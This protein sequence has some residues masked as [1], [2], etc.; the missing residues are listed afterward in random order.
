[1]RVLMI[2]GTAAHP[3]GVEAFCAR[4]AEAFGDDGDIRLDF[5]PAD[6]AFLPPRLWPSL[7]LRAWRTVRQHRGRIGGIWLHYVNL[8]DLAYLAMARLMGVP[9][10]VTPHLGTNWRSQSNPL[11]RNISRFLL[12]R[13]KG[14]ALLSPTQEREIA[15]PAHVRRWQVRTF[16]PRHLWAQPVPERDASRPLRLIHSARLSEGKGSFLFVDLCAI[17]RDRGVPFS[18]CIT[19]GADAQTMERL[20][21]RIAGHDLTDRIAV[22]G[23]V[24]VE[25]QLAQLRAADVL[26]H[27]SRIDSYPLIVLE[28]LACGVFPVCMELAGARDMMQSYAGRLVSPQTPAESA[29]DIL[30]SADPAALRGEALAAAERVRADHRWDECVALLKPAMTATFA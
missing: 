18:A 21:A 11:L 20:H 14:I 3:G 16:L 23:L 4:A 10:L 29:A 17:L 1:M 30:S 2:G 12:G 24:D 13:A 28:S 25:E 8:P 27:L 9:V 5:A 7:A 19:G 26:V 6:T 15:L 22:M